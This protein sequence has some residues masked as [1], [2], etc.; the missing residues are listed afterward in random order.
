MRASFSRKGWNALRRLCHIGTGAASRAAVLAELGLP[1]DARLLI[2]SGRVLPIK[3]FD[4]LV[5]ALPRVLAQHPATYLLLY[6]PDRGGTIDALRAQV[7]G[8]GLH[9][10]VRFLGILPFD[11]QGCY[12]AAADLSGRVVAGLFAAY[13]AD[14]ALLPERWRV[15]LP[16]AE[17]WRSRHI[18]DFIAGMTDRFAVARYREVV[19]PIELPLDL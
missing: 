17:P 2:T 3:G 6:G 18:A 13:A 4:T 11:G 12:L 10:R 15:S 19:G 8:L 16:D 9:E 14:P 5:D 7:A 1:D